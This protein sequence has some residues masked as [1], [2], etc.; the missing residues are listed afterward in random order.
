M[1]KTA[2]L[3]YLELKRCTRK[4]NLVFLFVFFILSL[5]SVNQG[6][7]DYQKVLIKKAE[8]QKIEKLMFQKIPDYTHYSFYGIRLYYQPSALDI[9]LSDQPAT[10]ELSAEF[11]SIASF[12]IDNNS[13]GK[14]IFIGNTLF[15][16][17]F[18]NILLVFVTFISLY[19]GYSPIKDKDFLKYNIGTW[20]CTRLFSTI[21]F[22]RF[23]F[24][25]TTVLMVFGFLVLFSTIRGITLTYIDLRAIFAFIGVVLIT[26][27][28]FITIGAK[29]GMSSFFV[30][31]SS[32]ILIL[33]ITLIMII[34]GLFNTIVMNR[35]DNIMSILKV[36]LAKVI[37]VFDF[38]KRA[39]ARN[40]SFD[41][42]KMDS[43]RSIVEEYYSN[44][45]QKM[46]AIENKLRGQIS[47]VVDVYNFLSIL[48]PTTFYTQTVEEAGSRGYSNFL[49]FYDFSQNHQDRFVRFWIDR[50]YYDER[51]LKMKS[52]IKGDEN[53]YHA[54]SRIPANFGWGLLVNLFYILVLYL[55]CLSSFKKMI[56][57]IDNPK[58]IKKSD[59]KI[60]VTAGCVNTF[61]VNRQET[62]S[63][64]YNLYS[65]MADP[66]QPDNSLPT[67]Q[68]QLF[69]NETRLS[70][71]TR[72][73][74]VFYMFDVAD[75][76][77]D[78]TSLDL[79]EFARRSGGKPFSYSESP[80]KER[81]KDIDLTLSFQKLELHQQLEIWIYCL[82]QSKGDRILV[83]HV[84][85]AL[86]I[87]LLLHLKTQL[88]QLTNTGAT[89][90]Y[91]VP[92]DLDKK[93]LREKDYNRDLIA[94]PDWF[95]DIEAH[96][97]L[98][99]NGFIKGEKL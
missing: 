17:S 22:F 90:L 46:R 28:F 83:S 24:L 30:K 71:T 57:R 16:L 11:N 77:E 37:K 84:D 31:S 58:P 73:G 56:H 10:S 20:T 41:L 52:Y 19:L 55:W 80:F 35:A 82:A 69:E 44:D 93:I 39:M 99:R 86:P 87:G 91:F 49:D 48:T 79:L 76:P 4:K 21:L 47:D 89:V 25:L 75:I 51:P 13:K 92:N 33:W 29:V 98:Y 68:L 8:F 67:G 1:H 72:S 40:G 32:G 3:F 60:E 36:E 59:R 2:A 97:E 78:V 26:A 53:L 65:G 62:K 15:K 96:R 14:S 94:L 81:I 6:I 66:K 85:K 34:P 50:V 42:K 45:Y 74:E 5:Y 12:D 64:I 27:L 61:Q 38:E 43:A 95:D 54:Q 70:G 88:D 23:I 9:F 18:S 63:Y 7:I